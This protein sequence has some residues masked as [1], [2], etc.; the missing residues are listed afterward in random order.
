MLADLLGP[1]RPWRTT[2]EELTLERLGGEEERAMQFIFC[3]LLFNHTSAVY[4]DDDFATEAEK[5]AAALDFELFENVEIDAEWTEETERL[6]LA[7]PV[8]EFPFSSLHTLNLSVASETG[9]ELFL[10]FWT[11]LF[12]VLKYF[13]LRGRFEAWLMMES[14]R[15]MLRR[16]LHR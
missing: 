1:F 7:S 10:V 9:D 15:F 4:Y 3:H 11:G 12:P 8:A 14:E 5:R 6:Y 16:S 2:I 13:R